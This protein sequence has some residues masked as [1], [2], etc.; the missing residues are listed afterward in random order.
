MKFAIFGNT[1]QAKKSSLAENLFKLLEKRNA[2]VY[3]CREF[4]HFLVSDLNL[5]PRAAGLF[6]ANDFTADMVISIAG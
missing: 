1:Y 6:D 4:N 3:I 5:T 2:E